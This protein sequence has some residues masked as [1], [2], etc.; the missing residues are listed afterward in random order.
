MKC[1]SCGFNNPGGMKFCGNC[2]SKLLVISE[3]EEFRLVAILFID[4]VGFTS[5]SDRRDPEEVKNILQKYYKVINEDIELYDGKIVKYIGDGI[6]S[7]FGHPF[8]HENDSERAILASI[9]NLKEITKLN[10]S[11]GLDIK[12]R[13]GINYGK[14]VVGK[15]VNNLDFFGNEINIAQR[16]E[17][18]AEPS[19][20]LVSTSIFK[21]TKGIFNFSL[22]ADKVQITSDLLVDGYRVDG[23]KEKRGRIRGVEGIYQPMIGRKKELAELKGSFESTYIGKSFNIISILGEAGIG[24]SRLFEEFERDIKSFKK[25]QIMKGR[26]LPYGKSFAYWPI[27]EILRKLFD[28]KVDDDNYSIA[29][30]IKNVLRKDFGED[31]FS[32]IDIHSIFLNLFGIIE[33]DELNI[34]QNKIQQML[35][36]I[37]ERIMRKQLRDHTILFII[38]DF[39][40]IDSSSVDL[41]SYLLRNLKDQPVCFIFISRAEIKENEKGK[42]LFNELNSF[43]NYKNILLKELDSRNS[44]LLVETILEIEK[45]PVDFKELITKHSEGNPFFMEEI[46]KSFIDEGILIHA[47]DKWKTTKKVEELKVPSSVEGV[48]R[49]RLD[50]LPLPER[51]IIQ[52]AAIIGKIFWHNILSSISNMIIDQPLEN[53]E[54]KEFIIK[55]FDSEYL[56]DSEYFFKHILIQ[57]VAYNGILVKVRKE[58]HKNIAKLLEKQ[59]N[60]SERFLNLLAYHFEHAQIFDKAGEYYLKLGLSQ[61][62]K[63]SNKEALNSFKKVVDFKKNL[64]FETFY[65]AYFNMA[66]VYST[67]GDNSKALKI[68]NELL[69]MEDSALYFFDIYQSIGDSYQKKSD[70]SAALDY[71]GK[72]EQFLDPKSNY[73]K[74]RIHNSFAWIHYLQGDNVK[75]KDFTHT[76]LELLPNC[77]ESISIEKSDNLKSH[78]YNLLGVY[79]GEIGDNEK[80]LEYYKKIE[81]IYI[82]KDKYLYLEACYNN[83]GTTYDSLGEYGDAIDCYNKSGDISKQVGERLGVAITLNNIGG[84]LLFCNDLKGSENAYREYLSINAEIE[85]KLGNGYGTAGLA[86]IALVKKDFKNAIEKFTT[87]KNIFTILGSKRLAAG[88]DIDLIDCYLEMGNVKKV[89]QILKKIKKSKYFENEKIIE[90]CNARLDFIKGEFQKAFEFFKNYYEDKLA[91]SDFEDLISVGYYLIKSLIEVGNISEISPVIENLK[92]RISEITGKLPPDLC[93]KYLQKEKSSFIINY[94]KS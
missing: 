79:Y 43:E 85:N 84:I 12:F 60:K 56:N 38:E 90:Y 41:I 65:K 87:A 6:L 73:D 62:E 51:K 39:H 21:Q 3:E 29:A 47:G 64:D 53:L 28:I 19:T 36:F 63:S 27:L 33:I 93:E 37:F 55:N 31:T 66:G 59:T 32:S 24:K 83:M 49:S 16:I 22:A 61:K 10:G 44:M 57:E 35:F 14:I 8:S 70:Y 80:A 82:E 94:K 92:N 58:V 46:I 23:L 67:I 15:V 77:D 76:S 13:Y 42:I 69:E 18:N 52:N 26:C 17:S 9:K 30:K 68:Y 74:I 45:L 88:I 86:R 72:A 5:F 25:L 40:W 81:S 78:V 1:E 75:F 48:I 89:N 11:L 4:M 2:G 34:P 20:I 54:S 91:K 71:Y 50:K 7:V